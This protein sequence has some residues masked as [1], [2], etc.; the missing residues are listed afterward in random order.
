MHCKTHATAWLTSPSFWPPPIDAGDLFWIIFRG[1]S[2]ARL[3]SLS[4]FFSVALSVSVAKNGDSRGPVHGFLLNFV[5]RE[6]RCPMSGHGEEEARRSVYRAGQNSSFSLGCHLTENPY[7]E[8]RRW[9]TCE[10]NCNIVRVLTCD[11]RHI[12]RMILPLVYHLF[13]QHMFDFCLSRFIR[14]IFYIWSQHLTIL[15]VLQLTWLLIANILL[16]CFTMRK[17]FTWYYM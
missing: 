3:L 10:K 4:L 13:I 15:T 7:R 16:K 2:V 9:T 6:R 1:Q 5:V 14:E 17:K 8:Q 12:I 11:I